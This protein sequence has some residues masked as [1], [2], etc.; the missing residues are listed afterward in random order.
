M[1]YNT[2]H[3][4]WRSSNR[5]YCPRRLPHM[6]K[7]IC[8][9][10]SEQQFCQRAVSVNC[11]GHAFKESSPEEASFSIARLQNVSDSQRCTWTSSR[12]AFVRMSSGFASAELVAALVSL[13]VFRQ[14]VCWRSWVHIWQDPNIFSRGPYSSHLGADLLEVHFATELYSV[15][16]PTKRR[17]IM[18]RKSKRLLPEQT[19]SVSLKTK[20]FQQFCIV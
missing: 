6:R 7:V 10:F 4:W 13:A 18:R 1:F 20:C 3:I 8:R 14:I 11:R 17:T 19:V 9:T 12:N 15:C 2:M 5:A 16:S